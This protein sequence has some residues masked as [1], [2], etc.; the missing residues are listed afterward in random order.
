MF[1]YKLKSLFK[2]GFV[3]I[4]FSFFV[5]LIVCLFFQ[6][7][8]IFLYTFIFVFFHEIAHILTAKKFGLKCKKLIITPIGQVAILEDMQVIPK[9][10]KIIIVLAGIILNLIFAYIFSFF[11]FEKAELIKNINLSI[12]FFNI[13]PIHPLDGGRFLQYYFNGKIGD[14]KVNFLIKK[15]S[16]FFSYIL[17]FLGFLQIIF[18]SYN[19]SLLC[20]GIYFL[21]INQ[22]EYLKFTFE[23][24][25]N[26]IEKNKINKIKNIKLLAV[27]IKTKNKDILLNLSQEYIVILHIFK[28]GE[29]IEKIYEKDFL[30]Y[31][32]KNG[33]NNYIEDILNLK[34]I[35]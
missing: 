35:F 22:D 11:N 5:V 32:E 19:I 23:F 27:D 8:D 1:L 31:I 30:C 29:F 28:N 21:K 7:L 4:N 9:W 10:K 12:A 20:L 13:L 6:I 26:L 18:I 24:Y 15:I 14:L 17:F 2:K 25:K 3:K 33:I 34:S 16:I